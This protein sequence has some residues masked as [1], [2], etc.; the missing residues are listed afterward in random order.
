MQ[1][2]Q[3]LKM[4]QSNKLLFGFPRS[5]VRAMAHKMGRSDADIIHMA[6]GRMYQQLF[7]ENV[8]YDPDQSVFE[9]SRAESEVQTKM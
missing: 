4:T 5:D 9:S 2:Q 7:P 8:N 3:V 1:H 6:L